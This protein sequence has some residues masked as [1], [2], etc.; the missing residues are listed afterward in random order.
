M[1]KRPFL[2]IHN[3]STGSLRDGLQTLENM[4]EVSSKNNMTFAI[5][6]HGSLAS[7]VDYYT[8]AKKFGIKYVPGNEI[9]MNKHRKRMFFLRDKIKELKEK[10]KAKDPE[11][12]E[13]IEH[14]L[15][16]YS[17]EFEE[18]RR[19]THLLL[20]AK[21]NFGLKNLF[22]LNNM[23]YL[24]GFYSKPINNHEELLNLPRDEK[25]DR[26]LIVTTACISSESSRYILNGNYNAALDYCKM[27]KEEF[28]DNFYLELQM[29]ELDMQ[30]KVN[31]S[32][33]EIHKELKIPM[34][35][36]T[37]AHY[38]NKTY[39]EAHQIFLLIQGDQTYSD[40]GKKQYRIEFEKG[41]V[42][43]R[44]KIDMGETFHKHDPATLK[45]DDI[46]DKKI[47]IRKVEVVDKVWII[48][49]ADLTFKTEKQIK[50]QS[51]QHAYL[52]DYIE[53]CIE[54]NKDIL[55]K[56]EEIN[57]DK[58]IKLPTKENDFESLKI[59]CVNSLAERGLKQ[60][61]YVERLKFEL[62]TIERSGFAGLFLIL[63]EIFLFAKSRKIP[64]GAARGSAGASLIAYLLGITRIDPIEW[65][66]NFS[67]F[68]TP[69]RA[70]TGKRIS[71]VTQD[72]EELTF[73]EF[74]KINIVRNNE[75]ITV[76]AKDILDTDEIVV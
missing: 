27:M 20:I 46:V 49:S 73:D 52:K 22:R 44:K 40:I 42:I 72:G 18:I 24:N 43:S 68:M 33:I 74:A 63:E 12:K 64:I 36:G 45:P 9:Y 54:N 2:S 58:Q 21:N 16:N 61:K 4:C 30:K 76:K 67:R 15:K 51:K 17:Y 48:E 31:E 6:E 23:A 3:H 34:T 71:I 38:L 59:K 62:D 56:I 69:E 55:E 5:T 26:G 32:L 35:I 19:Y 14:E 39:S 8:N 37:D 7:L 53:D 1:S 10:A 47:K 60:K 28:A 11:E 75:N 50:E 66:L 29:S 25:G 13:K 41:G 70:D 65:D 57:L